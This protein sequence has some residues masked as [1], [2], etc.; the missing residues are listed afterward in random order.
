MVGVEDMLRTSSQRT[1]G[2]RGRSLLAFA[3]V[4][5]AYV[6]AA[7]LGLELSVAHG[8]ITPVWPPTGI[9]LAALLLLG[10]RYWPAVAMGAFV[11][12]ATSGV[13][14]DVAAAI[15][16]GNTLA[17]LAGVYLLRR[18]DFR[19]SLERVGDVL[20][21]TL[22]AAFAATTIS[23]TNGV[24]TLVLA[25][26]PAASPYG[27]AW[28]LWWLGDAMGVLLVAPVL[29][30][31]A[32]RRPKLDRKRLLEALGLVALLAGTSAAVFFGGGWRYPYPIFPLLVL[33]T[34]R[35]RTRSSRS[36]SSPPCAFASSA[37][38]SAVSSLPGSRSAA[39]SRATR[40]SREM[41]RPPRRCSRRCSVLPRSASSC[42]A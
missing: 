41:R 11:T 39:S 34:L 28:L 22:L 14:A 13:S 2:V 40:R 4:A 10:P 15:S 17:A 19:P 1:L 24:T 9:A 20:W 31:G 26:S 32:T 38:P 23:A 7:K 42:S 8:V 27:S 37:P 30:I 35:F 21:L 12:N 5:G 25:G 18:V 16:V 36:S 29:L 33:A 6:G 3:A